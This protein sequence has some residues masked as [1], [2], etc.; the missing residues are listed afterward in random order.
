MGN[1]LSKKMCF[2]C[3]TGKS[4]EMYE[5]IRLLREFEQRKIQERYF[6]QCSSCLLFEGQ[7]E[8]NV[9]IQKCNHVFHSICFYQHILSNYARKQCPTC[10]VH[11]EF[12]DL[13][14]KSVFEKIKKFLVTIWKQDIHKL[15]RKESCAICLD[16]LI[17]SDCSRITKCGHMFHGKCIWKSLT[18]LNKCPMCMEIITFNDIKDLDLNSPSTS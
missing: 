8:I 16:G 10:K 12:E 14:I 11:I 4:W 6:K 5:I 15:R 2:E 1:P 18:R 17:K 9:T 7:D 13:I 3:T